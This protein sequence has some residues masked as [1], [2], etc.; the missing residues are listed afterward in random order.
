MLIADA[1]CRLWDSGLAVNRLIDV[2]FGGRGGEGKERGKGLRWR[3]SFFWMYIESAS[4][5][6]KHFDFLVFFTFYMN[7]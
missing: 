6:L 1:A 5:N 2:W 3:G 4:G 7:L